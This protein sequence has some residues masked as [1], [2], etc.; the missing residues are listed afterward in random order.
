MGVVGLTNSGCATSKIEKEINDSLKTQEEVI[1]S[2][3]SPDY[4][5]TFPK[6]LTLEQAYTLAIAGNPSLDAIEE[7]IK[8][9]KSKLNQAYSTY[10]PMVSVNAGTTR[11]DQ[12]PD[13]KSFGGLLGTRTVN[14]TSLDLFWL[15][16]DGFSRKNRILSAK[17]GVY[18][19]EQ[20]LE[21]ARRLLLQAVSK[22]YLTTANAK[23]LMKISQ[24]EGNLS[25]EFLDQ[26]KQKEEAGISNRIS[27]NNF[28]L[29]VNNSSISYIQS[30]RDYEVGLVV[31][32]ELLGQG[33]EPITSD[34]ALEWQDNDVT[35]KIP[36]LGNCIMK[37]YI[38]RPDLKIIESR[39]AAAKT[40]TES[41]K[42]E[43]YPKVYLQGSYGGSSNDD[44]NFSGDDSEFMFG[45]YVSWNIFNGF[46]TTEKLN[47]ANSEIASLDKLRESLRNQVASEVMQTY[48]SIQHNIKRLDLEK[49]NVTLNKEIYDQTKE[50]Y[51]EGLI[52]L[53]RVNEVLT[54]LF[55]AER[56]FS[57]RK[58]E[59]LSL[60]EQLDAQTGSIL[61]HDN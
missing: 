46:E 12:V 36:S 51:K 50:Q 42:G 3:F 15:V 43:Y 55:V 19:A 41:I 39:I 10:Y 52:T 35:P 58:I 44:Y 53:T 7:R 45:A 17:H 14:E 57:V 34:L 5:S 59:L 61:N 25:K 9:A 29:R 6:K 13:N 32:M 2:K 4:K 21:E 18:S 56:A 28:K 27:V 11:M 60:L 24:A 22:A 16:F 48:K 54:D 8:T 20:Q 47:E 26:E 40:G 33:N 49:S 31:L 23:Q 38:E 30:S 1:Y 37:C